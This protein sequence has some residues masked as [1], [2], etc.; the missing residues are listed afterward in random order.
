MNNSKSVTKSDTALFS[1]ELISCGVAGNIVVTYPW[2]DETFAANAGQWYPV[3]KATRIKAATT[4]T[5][6]VQA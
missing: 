1:G 4:A 3:S 6:L 2:G 5:G